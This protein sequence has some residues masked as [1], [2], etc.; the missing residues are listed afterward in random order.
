METSIQ[1]ILDQT[2]LKWIFVGGKGGVGK[3]TT[4]CSVASQLAKVRESVLLISTDPAHNLSDAFGQKF[5]KTPSTVTGFNNLFAMEIDPTVEVETGD[6]LDASSKSLL[7]DL[8]SSVPGIDEAMTFAEIMKQVQSM[9]Y[10]VIVFD[11]APTGHTLRL[12]SFPTILEKAFS[13][14]LSIKNKFSN[15]FQQFSSATSGQLGGSA[16]NAEE[17]I[18]NKLEQTKS[19]I[20]AVIKQF[21]DPEATTFVCVCIPEFLSLYET[22]RLIVALSQ[23]KINTQNIVINQLVMPAKD[24]QCKDCKARK[25]MQ[26]KYLSQITDL[27]SD[28]FH[29][30]KVPLLDDEVRGVESIKRFGALLVNPVTEKE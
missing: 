26:E 22:D 6:V 20:D 21:T 12:L 3:T 19:T 4:S 18:M 27:Y 15:V 23:M 24:S 30:T 1:N 8:I 5:S 11:T 2:S 25:K 28:L 14:L 10:S 29:I 17:K 13:K 7:S 16:E 9:T